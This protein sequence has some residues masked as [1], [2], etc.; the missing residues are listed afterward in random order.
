MQ[1]INDMGW[2]IDVEK[3]ASYIKPEQIRFKEEI[4]VK[5]I[6]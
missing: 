3:A 1:A 6:A 5:G 2:P 4:L